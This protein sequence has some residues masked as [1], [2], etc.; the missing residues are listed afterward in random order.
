MKFQIAIIG[1]GVVGLAIANELS[2]YY[3]NIILIEKWGH[4]GEETSS[5][6]SE[7]IHAGIYYPQNSLK[8]KFCVEGN[9]SIYEYC[10]KFNIPHQRCTKLIVAS[11]KDELYK[12]DEI[13][14]NA[15]QLGARELKIIGKSEA[16]TL[17]P[18]VK[19]EAAI[20]SGSTGIIDS[21][22]FM[23]S[24]E[25]NSIK[26]NVD[27]IYNHK[28][29][30]IHQSNNWQLTLQSSDGD[31]FEIESEVIINSAGLSADIV[32]EMSGI[33]IYAQN[34][35]LYYAKGHYFKLKA[36]KNNLVQ[37]LIYPIPSKNFSGLGIHVTKDLGGGVKLGPD[38]FYL[39]NNEIDYSFEPNLKEKFFEA[40]SQ[41]LQGVSIDDLEPDYTGIRPK[42]Q[43]QG[44]APKDFI[45]SKDLVGQSYIIN[46]LG[47]E[48]PGLTSSLE[49][50]KYVK[51]L[52]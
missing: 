47:I 45:I 50:A 41:Y 2:K 8:A 6:N 15:C 24:L 44:E 23:Q 3:S 11:S 51:S 39:P 37:R 4:F 18:N 30:S 52:L 31:E 36:S 40:V 28:L 29:I 49:I 46:L 34:Y 22:S 33:D 20:L 1:A 25:T 43:K 27:I 19:V 9:I 32:A 7:V 10:E 14:N 48:S 13:Y 38:V 42:L 21:H 5:R 12:I 26:N 16:E 35:K 17:E